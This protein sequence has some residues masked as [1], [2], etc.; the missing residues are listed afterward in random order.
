[1]AG[2][3]L[4]TLPILDGVSPGNIATR[5]LD[6]VGTLHAVQLRFKAANGDDLTQAQIINDVE[7]IYL[8]ISGE[9]IWEMEPQAF[10]DIFGTYY[11]PVGTPALG[12]IIQID[13]KPFWWASTALANM[14]AWGM[15]DIAQGRIQV[16]VR[17]KSAAPTLGTGSIECNLNVTPLIQPL[18]TH[19]SVTRYPFTNT[20]DGAHFDIPT[21]P[22]QA[23]V[24][25]LAYFLHG[26]ERTDGTTALPFNEAI[27][28]IVAQFDN[29]QMRQEMSPAYLNLTSRQVGRVPNNNIIPLDFNLDGNPADFIR[30]ASVAR[31][32]FRLRMKSGY[33]AGNFTV[34]RIGAAGINPSAAQIASLPAQG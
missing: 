10:Y 1:M 30:L 15:Q 25:V 19:W 24:G 32:R 2:N 17:I 12:G 34:Y 18:G 5:S 22:N 8:K 4:S 3:I 21:L 9:T 14:L 13:L 20:D 23:N 27:E 31:Q 33:D 7:S 29:T 16:G 26:S 28:S 6:A 11:R